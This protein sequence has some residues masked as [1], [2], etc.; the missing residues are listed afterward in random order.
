MKYL[1]LLALV[2]LSLLAGCGKKGEVEPQAPFEIEYRVVSPTGSTL[3]SQVHYINETGG[4]TY[5]DDVP[6]PFSVKLKMAPKPGNFAVVGLLSSLEGT[7]QSLTGSILQNGL[8][9]ATETGT[10]DPAY[11]NVVYVKP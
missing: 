9:K 11:V 7:P 5:L 8:V 1:L 3:A 2:C 4:M 6:L 10:G